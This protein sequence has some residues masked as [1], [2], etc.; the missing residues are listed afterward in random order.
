MRSL[1]VTGTDDAF[2][3]LARDLIQSLFQWESR[4]FSDLACFDLGLGQE[5]REWIARYAAHV[6]AP[7]WR[8]E[9]SEK[10]RREHP[11]WRAMTSR[12]FLREYF[13]GYDVYFWIDADAWVQ[14]RFAIEW[15][16]EVAEQAQLAITPEVDRAYRH[17][18]EIVE[19][20]MRN[21]DV[22]YGKEAVSR[23]F[24]ETYFNL[25]VFALRA[26]APHWEIWAKWFAT[27]LASAQG[28]VCSDQTALNYAIWT[29]GLS[30]SPL[31][32]YCNWLVH[33]KAPHYDVKLSKFR[34]PAAPGHPI[35]IMHLAG[36]TKDAR[37]QIQ[38]ETGVRTISLRYPGAMREN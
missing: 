3:P 10:Q 2:M 20:R 25:G 5:N 37:L 26:D 22:Y 38:D 30:A 27:G 18:T 9:I 35:G 12:P 7:R 34:E 6:V 8:L 29:E 15:Y 33:L 1:I 28:N 16:L 31:P 36:N 32:A 17:S 19:W 14:E 4:P 11:S 23:L 24:F 21:L 13:P